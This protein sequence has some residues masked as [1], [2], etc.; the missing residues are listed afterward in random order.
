[1]NK[2]LIKKKLK[3]NNIKI[4]KFNIK[5]DDYILVQYNKEICTRDIYEIHRCLSERFDG[6][7]IS[8]PK[9]LEFSIRDRDS[10]IKYL[11]DILY[12]LKSK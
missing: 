1:M 6:K 7:V 3:Q 10:I 4:N 11:E 12:K 5:T 2:R 9:N 8:L